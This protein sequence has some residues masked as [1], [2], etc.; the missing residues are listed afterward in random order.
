MAEDF[1]FENS[2]DYTAQDPFESDVDA[3][4]DEQEHSAT[5]LEGNPDI[6]PISDHT[7][8]ENFHT[9]NPN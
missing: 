9:D 5:L 2:R 6:F 1:S 7:T 3:A 4:A 8:Y